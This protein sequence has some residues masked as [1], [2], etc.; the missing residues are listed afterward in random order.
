MFRGR[1]STKCLDS[2][3]EKGFGQVIQEK[4]QT[5]LCDRSEPCDSGLFGVARKGAVQNELT[6]QARLGE[7]AD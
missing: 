5:V 7:R 2:L 3:V 4:D 6:E 1:R